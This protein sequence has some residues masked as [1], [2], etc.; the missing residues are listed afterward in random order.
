MSSVNS[1]KS[2]VYLV[3][4]QVLA[5]YSRNSPVWL[6]RRQQDPDFPKP[7]YVAGMRYWRLTDLEAYEAAEARKVAPD[8]TL[9]AIKARR[10][11][12]AT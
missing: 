12:R 4:R 7:I 2:T 1:E 10:S 11:N 8:N 6:H 9:P 3:G 5:R